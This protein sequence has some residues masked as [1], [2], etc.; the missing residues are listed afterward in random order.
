M[1]LLRLR[2]VSGLSGSIERLMNASRWILSSRRS[3]RQ[4]SNTVNRMAIHVESREIR[5]PVCHGN[6]AAKV[7]GDPEKSHPS[8]RIIAVH[9]WQDNANS[10]DPL[11]LDAKNGLHRFLKEGVCVTSLDFSGHGLSSHLPPGS[12]YSQHTYAIDILTTAKFL[13][14]NEFS[15]L[16][17]S[18]GGGM[19]FYTAFLHPE[20]VRKLAA[21]DATFPYWHPTYSFEMTI[22]SSHSL[23]EKFA[24]EY[25]EM[26]L[27]KPKEYTMEEYFQAV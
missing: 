8:R 27:P 22:E 25:L 24:S 6:L 10:F 16:G 7:W 4:M 1:E 14:W 21:L 13:E 9:G 20:R 26:G 19:G 12:I 23:F 2:N 15:L 18:M 11:M 3:S 17:H 5:I